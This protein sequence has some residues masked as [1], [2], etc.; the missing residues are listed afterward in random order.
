[1]ILEMCTA[2]YEEVYLKTKLNIRMF[3]RAW[4]P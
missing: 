2:I 1:M 4:G 3:Q